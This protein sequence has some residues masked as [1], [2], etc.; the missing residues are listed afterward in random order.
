MNLESFHRVL[1]EKY[2]CRLKVRSVYDCSWYLEKYLLMK[3][4]DLQ[5]KQIRFKR[6][7]KLKC[8][9]ANH[10]KVEKQSELK[11]MVINSLDYNS[12]YVQSF[13]DEEVMY[14]VLKRELKECTIYEGEISLLPCTRVIARTIQLKIICASIFTPLQ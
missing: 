8:L 2:M 1:K 10:K 6:T 3:G 9:R 13:I 7:N 11:S 5:K 12:W 14:N 4:N